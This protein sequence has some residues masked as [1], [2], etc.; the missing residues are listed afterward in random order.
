M[1][2]P[3]DDNAVLAAPAALTPAYE[4][5]TIVDRQAVRASY[6][7][8]VA[9]MVDGNAPH[10][11]VSGP[12][13]TGKSLLTRHVLDAQLSEGQRPVVVSCAD[14][15]SA[16]GVAVA[17]ANA[18]DPTGPHLSSTGHAEQAVM[19][20]L[21]DRL[22]DATAT[23]VVLDDIDAVATDLLLPTIADATSDTDLVTIL[24]AN[25]RTVRNEFSYPIRRRLCV[26][27][28]HVERY[29]DEIVR[30]ILNS[31]ADAAFETGLISPEVLDKSTSLVQ[32]EFD[33]DVGQGIRLLAFVAMVADE[34]GVERITVDHVTRARDR[35]VSRRIR[36]HLAD[37]SVHRAGTL[38]AVLDCVTGGGDAP[39]IGDLY[40][41]Y[42]E[43]CETDGVDPISERGFHDHLR[44]LRNADI[45]AVTSHRSGTPGHYYRYHL[46]VEPSVVRLTLA[47]TDSQPD[48]M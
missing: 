43:Q 33:G 2:R 18:L 12:R 8:V 23:V 25:D 27:D 35:L 37:S 4:D 10:L 9:E 7:D 19:N 14:H 5:A 38:R 42:R 21:A 13:G 24:V 40:A 39:R 45:V 46:A 34:A 22:R 30:Q 3:G 6:R 11:F 17:L 36:D 48:A 41:T 26:R 15:D 32:S 16:Y 31:R 29:D 44:A 28:L 47:A 1:V 20:T